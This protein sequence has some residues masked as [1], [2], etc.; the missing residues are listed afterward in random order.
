MPELGEVEIV[1]RNLENWWVGESA[2][3][4]QLLDDDL[5]KRGSADDLNRAMRQ[6][7]VAARRRG[8]YLWMEMERGDVVMFHFRMT[9]K[10]TTEAGPQPDYARLAW[11][12]ANLASGNGWLVFKDSRRLGQV[13]WFAPGELQDYEPIAEMGPEPYGLTG[14]DLRQLLPERRQLKT[15]LMDQRVIAGIGNIA[16]SELFW[17]LRIPPRVKAGALSGDTIDRLAVELP[18]FFD[19]LIERQMADEVIYMTS[20][21]AAHNPFDVYGREGEACARCDT[22]IERTKVGGRSS[23]FCPACQANHSG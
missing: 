17:R 3:N 1:R 14:D 18:K 22:E 15:A 12:I 11:Q 4:V 10:I 2:S 19:Q 6:K 9:G 16:I 8:K 7:A 5:L 21:K 20:G 13:E 23:Y